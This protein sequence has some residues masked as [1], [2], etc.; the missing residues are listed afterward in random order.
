MTNLNLKNSENANKR[1]LKK[2]G[3]FFTFFIFS[4]LFFNSKETAAS[5]TI[6]RPSTHNLGMVGHWTF[7]GGKV[8]NGVALDLTANG[9]NGNLINIATSTFYS[10]GKIGQGF[11]FDNVNDYVGVLRINNSEMSVSAWFY[12]NAN[13]FESN[14]DPIV[15]SYYWNADVQ[16]REG[17]MLSFALLASTCG[18]GGSAGYLCLEFVGATTNG[19][20]VTTKN[21]YAPM[22]LISKNGTSTL[23][24][25]HTV[26]TYDSASGY[27]RLYVNGVLRDSDLH[28]AGNTIVPFTYTTGTCYNLNKLLIG[29]VCVNAGYW[30]GKID[31]V[32][33]YNR[34]LSAGEVEL[35]YK[36]GR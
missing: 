30:N 27:Q 1:N 23:E 28:V 3:F 19:S 26:A 21:S 25:F 2:F 18:S 31:D 35:L 12:K 15:G 34:A 14:R 32:R 36:M 16:L 33:I 7:D 13:N 10:I 11:E 29:Y 8:V 5:F 17:F 6:S 20:T 22:G 24:W 4:F 9:N